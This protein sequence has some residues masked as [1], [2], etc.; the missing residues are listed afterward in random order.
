MFYK[1]GVF[2]FSVWSYS[3]FGREKKAFQD[4]SHIEG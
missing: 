1:L 2:W 3:G 4:E